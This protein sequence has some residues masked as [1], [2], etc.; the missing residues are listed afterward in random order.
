MTTTIYGAA[1][2]IAPSTA[3]STAALSLGSK[4]AWVPYPSAPTGFDF[5]TIESASPSAFVCYVFS[6][7]ASVSLPDLVKLGVPLAPG[8]F[9][10]GLEELRPQP[11][12]D[13]ALETGQVFS[14]INGEDGGLL[15]PAGSVVDVT[16]SP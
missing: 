6:A 16:F 1:S 8:P 10:I 12:L 11:T 7:D 3:G 4:L 2:W 13:S 5:L 9:V 15:D 14:I